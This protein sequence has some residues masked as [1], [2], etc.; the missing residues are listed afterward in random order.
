MHILSLLPQLFFLAPFS[1]IITRG[2]LAALL[3]IAAKEQWSPQATALSRLLIGIEGVIGVALALG[4]MTQAAAIAT[5][6]ICGI[7]IMSPQMRPYPLSS[8]LLA[9]VMAITLILSGAGLFAI[10]L[11]L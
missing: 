11:P 5:L 4:F 10:D 6:V 7:W 1:L 9:I 8:V 2:A 3:F